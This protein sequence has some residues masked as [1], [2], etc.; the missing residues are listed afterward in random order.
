[1]PKILIVDDD[2][3]IRNLLTQILENFEEHG[4]AL[5]SVQEGS[6]ALDLIKKDKPDIVFLDVMMPQINGFEV[7]NIVKNEY[8]MKDVYIIM[9]TARGQEVDRQKALDYG[10]DDYI[11]KPFNINEITRKVS[12]ILKMEIS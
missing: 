12:E 8:Q 3:I 1:M 4:V 7:C 6:S 11:T 2:P 10:A 5:L 9:L